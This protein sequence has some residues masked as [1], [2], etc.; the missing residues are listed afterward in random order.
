MERCR[1][2]ESGQEQ[3]YFCKFFES[4]NQPI[5]NLNKIERVPQAGLFGESFTGV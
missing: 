1:R 2:E 5:N 4:K 3:L